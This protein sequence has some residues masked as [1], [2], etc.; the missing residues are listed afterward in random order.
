VHPP[1]LAAFTPR[2]VAA[3]Q[4]GDGDIPNIAFLLLDRLPQDALAPH[5]PALAR[6]LGISSSDYLVPALAK[7]DLCADPEVRAVMCEALESEDFAVRVDA[8]RALDKQHSGAL[9]VYTPALFQVL[10]TFKHLASEDVNYPMLSES[11]GEEMRWLAFELLTR[12]EPS[13]LAEHVQPAFQALGDTDGPVALREMAMNAVTLLSPSAVAPHAQLVLQTMREPY[14]EDTAA[15]KPGPDI[16]MRMRDIASDVLTNLEVPVLAGLVPELLAALDEK[17]W[18]EALFVLSNL[19]LAMLSHYIRPMLRTLIYRSE[20]AHTDTGQLILERMDPSALATH[21]DEF[22]EAL[23][24]TEDQIRYNALKFLKTFPLELIAAHAT[25]LRDMLAD[26]DMFVQK[27]AVKL[28]ARL[29]GPALADGLATLPA[30]PKV[31]A[32]LLQALGQLPASAMVAPP[33]EA[34]QMLQD[35]D[36]SLRGSAIEALD[37]LDPSALMEDVLVRMARDDSDGDVRSCAM[38]ALGKLP[39]ARLAEH[40]PA[41][42]KGLENSR[43]AV[44]RSAAAALQKVDEVV[45]AAHTPVP[46]STVLDPGKPQHMRE[47]AAEGLELWPPTVLAPHLAGLRGMLVKCDRDT[48]SIPE[49][50]DRILQKAVASMPASAVASVLKVHYKGKD[51]ARVRQAAL[52]RVISHLPAELLRL[53]TPLLMSLLFDTHAGVRASASATLAKLDP[54]ELAKKN[55]ALLQLGLL[56]P[57]PAVRRAA[58]R[59]LCGLPPENLA[60]HAAE[61][62]RMLWDSDASVQHEAMHETERMLKNLQTPALKEQLRRAAVDACIGDGMLGRLRE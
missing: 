2:L 56:D 23:L 30:Q 61:V 54:S 44:Q 11:P 19:P 8:L 9:T 50:K 55:P 13:E 43:Y 21:T 46:L 17:A 47:G 29:P 53:H 57:V 51:H 5:A 1:T 37:R 58:L 28:L 41:L 42:L 10:L 36:A 26:P 62:L 25:T 33:P 16:G 32:G 34:V 38:R 7:L 31:R 52:N 45:L 4:S 59:N 18:D 39:A 22:Q 40:V 24:H 15:Y 12:V 14:N 48:R 49:S 27:R 35:E 60:P 6:R 20:M 3:V